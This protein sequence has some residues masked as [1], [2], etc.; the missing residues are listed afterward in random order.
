MGDTPF[1]D[2]GNNLHFYFIL[3]TTSTDKETEDGG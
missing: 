1:W 2:S 3:L